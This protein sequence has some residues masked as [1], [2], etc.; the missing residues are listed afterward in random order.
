M[1]TSL[2][3]NNLKRPRGVVHIHHHICRRHKST[4]PLQLLRTRPDPQLPPS[5]AFYPNQNS[6]PTVPLKN[7]EAMYENPSPPPMIPRCSV[8]HYLFPP[9][10][11]GKHYRYYPEPD[12][13]VIAYI[14]GITGRELYRQ[15]IPVQSM[16]LASGL[17]LLGLKKGDV[18]GIFGMN[19][20]DWIEAL[21][22]SQALNL[23]VSP[24]NYA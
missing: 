14:D 2:L 20:L 12:P 21:Y 11:K 15:E 10:R 22:G 9:K 23:I 8:F 4:A 18:V 13:R 1:S 24:I 5:F 6:Y 17:G 16:W 7:P 3:I 19:S